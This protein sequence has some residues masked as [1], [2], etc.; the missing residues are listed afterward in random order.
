MSSTT[1]YSD[2]PMS[3]LQ[4]LMLIAVEQGATLN[5]ATDW[6]LDWGKRH[7]HEAPFEYRT[8]TQWRHAIGTAGW[9]DAQLAS[10][11][12]AV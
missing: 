8:Y 3:R 2:R 10:A 4:F 1:I 7:P 9:N 6:A 12:A 11:Q 5:E